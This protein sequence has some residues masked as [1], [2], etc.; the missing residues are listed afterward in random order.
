MRR[1]EACGVR[2]DEDIEGEVET[3]ADDGSDE[4]EIVALMT[5]CANQH[6]ER[7]ELDG[8]G[9]TNWIEGTS[10]NDSDEVMAVCAGHSLSAELA[11]GGN[12]PPGFIGSTTLGKGRQVYESSAE[13][14]SGLGVAGS[15]A[16][17]GLEAQANN[18]SNVAVERAV[19]PVEHS[20]RQ[21]QPKSPL[22]SKSKSKKAQRTEN[23]KRSKRAAKRKQAQEAAG[24]SMKAVAIRRA[25]ISV[26]HQA[27]GYAIASAPHASTGYVGK[28]GGPRWTS[29]TGGQANKQSGTVLQELSDRGF[30]IIPWDG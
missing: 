25:A 15:K 1:E 10:T 17:E 27:N 11:G 5:A 2:F 4:E 12:H 21:S 26:A 29:P 7:A 22:K 20:T 28:W 30:Q 16:R 19:E 24:T 18:V 3:N 13:V 23:H 8:S 6:H 9:G 14:S